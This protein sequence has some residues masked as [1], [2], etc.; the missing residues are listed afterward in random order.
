MQFVIIV[1]HYGQLVFQPNCTYPKWTV[2]IVVPQNTFLALLFYDFYRKTY[3]KKDQRSTTA[4]SSDAKTC[5]TEVKNA[6]VNAAE[7]KSKTG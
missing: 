6:A 5:V 3:F 7:T 1:L 2:G 4:A